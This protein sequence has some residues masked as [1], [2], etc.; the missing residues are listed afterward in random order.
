[1]HQKSHYYPFLVLVAALFS[2]LSPCANAL[3]VK[4]ILLGG[5]SNS[6]GQAGSSGLPTS[7]VDLQQPQTDVLFFYDGNPSLTTLQP[8]SGGIPP[9]SGGFGPEVTFGRAVADASPSVAYAIIKHGEN[10]TALYNDWNP[11]TGASYSRFRDTIADGLTALQA[12]G[13]TTEIVG[14]LWHQGESDAAEGQQA[15]YATNLPAFI[16]DVRTRYGANL[17]FLIGEIRRSNGAAFVTVADAQIAVAAA[18][19][20]AQ[21]VP[22]SDLT[23][24]D[25]VHFD[26]PGTITL[27][28][29][30]ATAY[31]ILTGVAAEDTTPPTVSVLS[32][33]RDATAVY[34]PDNLVVTF[35][36]NIAIGTGNITIKDLDSPSQ[37]AIPVGDAQISVSGAVLTINPTANL[38]PGTNYAIQIEA[39]AIDDSS[40]NSFAGISDDTTWNFATAQPTTIIVP[41]SA[42]AGSTLGG[43]DRN[44]AYTIGAQGFNEGTQQHDAFAEGNSWTSD[45]KPLASNLDIVFDLGANYNLTAAFIWNWNHTG[46]INAGVKDLEVL[47][48]STV[49]GPTTSLG[50]FTLSKGTGSNNYAGESLSISATDVREVTISVIDGHGFLHDG[51]E[52]VGLSEVR[53][54]GVS[55]VVGGDFASYISDPSFGLD[56]ADQNFDDD[57]DGDNLS[58]GLEAWF[59]THPGQFNAGLA[60]ISTNGNITTFI[61]PQNATAPDDLTGY[62]E[63]S[64]NLVDWYAGDGSEGPSGGP[65]VT[66]VANTIGTTTTVTATVSGEADRT[67]LR[68]GVNQN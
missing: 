54:G 45:V 41:T 49:G 28:E 65:T 3:D 58:N 6:V 16:A 46:T 47:V 40:G 29:R 50:T 27:G 35:D 13:H 9:G 59:G 4:V 7:P 26:A 23:F 42:T 32:P 14:M 2:A 34:P 57:P 19:A 51:G 15:N 20:N 25:A 8:G 53:F 11:T 63:W 55:A 18:D 48:A 22:A 38:A 24:G 52:L 1:M 61:H 60:N 31:A 37:M 68:A 10:D 62:Y 66:I 39:T 17:P 67:F 36:E 21:F 5:Q 12:A 43:Y 56:P 30:F 64:P 44:I 33:L